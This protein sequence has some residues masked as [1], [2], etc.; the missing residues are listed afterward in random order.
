[1]SSMISIQVFY[2]AQLREEQNCSCEERS[3][4]QGMSVSSL[5]TLIFG[6][7]PNGIRFA[8][9][10]T[11]VDPDVVPLDGD[12]VAFLPPLGGG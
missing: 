5:F 8:V 1:M 3:I 11:Y 2:F 10:Q 6:R 9:N 4:E 7:A 12:E